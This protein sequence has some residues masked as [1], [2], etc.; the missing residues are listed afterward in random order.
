[1]LAFSFGILFLISTGFFFGKNF[2]KIPISITLVLY[3]TDTTLNCKVI[4][5]KSKFYEKLFSCSDIYRKLKKNILR[6]LPFRTTIP[7]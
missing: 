6:K 2:D 3:F 1:M 7:S 4:V 5:P